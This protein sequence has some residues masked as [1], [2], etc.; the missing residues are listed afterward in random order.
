MNYLFVKMDNGK[1]NFDKVLNLLVYDR[2]GKKCG[3]NQV[4]YYS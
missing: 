1:I 4:S 3:L 2:I